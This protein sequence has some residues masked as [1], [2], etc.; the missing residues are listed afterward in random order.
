M[1]GETPSET[2]APYSFQRLSVGPILT[3][4]VYGAF[5]I[6]TKKMDLVELKKNEIVCDS[7]MVARKFDMKHNKVT[8]VIESMLSDYPDLSASSTGTKSPDFRGSSTTP[9]TL[10]KCWKEE[11]NYKGQDYTAYLMNREFFSLLMGRFTT[12]RAREWQRRFNASFYEMEKA[13]LQLDENGKSSEWAA[14]RLQSKQMR[15]QQTDVIKEFVEY[16]TNQGSQS[17][18]YYYK[19]ITNA[20]YKALQLIQHKKPKIR[21]TLNVME[22]AQ[23]MVAE[24]VAKQSLRKYMEAGEHYKTIFVLVKQDLESLGGSMML[25]AS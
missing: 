13:L 12:K 17:A 1:R 2:N 14:T 25:E 11:R 23:L 3:W 22:L 6:G 16:A 9:K 4:L 10:E 18:K 19:H 15:L 24:N 5:F 21:D 20:T 8:D 7:S